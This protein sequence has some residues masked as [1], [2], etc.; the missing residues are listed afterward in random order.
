MQQLAT[1]IERSVERA[2]PVRQAVSPAR[3]AQG[4]EAQ[5]RGDQGQLQSDLRRAIR[6][7]RVPGRHQH[8]SPRAVDLHAKGLAVDRQQL[9]GPSAYKPGR[10]RLHSGHYQLVRFAA[11]VERIVGKE[12]ALEIL[13]GS[14]YCMPSQAIRDRI[15]RDFMA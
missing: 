15:T 3:P 11:G 13:P 2:G 1:A 7:H 12:T 6:V 5:D 4:H 9:H 14:M 10:A 8:P